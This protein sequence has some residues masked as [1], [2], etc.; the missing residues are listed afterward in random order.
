MQLNYPGE[1]PVV[2][3][4]KAIIKAIQ[5]NQVVIIAGETGSGKTTQLP[6][7]CVEALPDLLKN[8]MIGITQPRRIA[9]SSV[10]ARVAEELQEMGHIV[11]HKIRFYDKTTAAT[12]I[13]FM[14]DGVLLAETK[15]DTLLQQYNVLIIDEAHERSLNIDFLLGYL[16][17][18]LPKRPELKL[19][20][21]S[22]TIDTEAFARHFA[23]APVIVV[24]GRSYPVEISYHP[25]GDIGETGAEKDEE[26][27]GKIEHA[28]AILDELFL[29]R[30][31]GDILL[32]L[33]TEQDIRQ[34]CALLE[35]RYQ[36]TTVLPLFGRLA[37]GDQAKIF[38]PAKGI[39]I[40]VATNVA[41]TSITVPGIRYVIDS[42]Y[43][44]ISR[45][46]VRARTTALP[47]S[48]ISQA[49]A[50]QRAGRAGRIAPGFCLRLY[51]EDDFLQR[52]EFTVPEI[53]RTNLAEVILQMISF[54][55]GEPENFPFLDA[56]N[57]AAIREGYTL[58]RELGAL[59]G[60]NRL[61]PRGR[62][63]ARLP[64]DPCISRILL[65][66]KEN[67]S[68]TE[69]TIIAAVLAIQDPRIRPAE[70]EQ[71][72]DEAH[73]RFRHKYS[74]FLSLLNIWQ[75]YHQDNDKPQS[76][77][78]LKK[79][80][81][82][83]YLSFQRMREWIDLH[84]QLIRIL[85]RE[86]DAF[87]FNRNPANY[88]QIHKALLCGFLRNIARKKQ[89]EGKGKYGGSAPK[90]KNKNIFQGGQNKELA[91]F[92]GSGLFAKPPEWILA[93]NFI[94]TS[95][96]YALTVAAIEP[97]WVEMA[98]SHLCN[99]SWSDPCWHK[100]SG[101][102]LAKETVSLFGL[103]VNTKNRV[104]FGKRNK[105]NSAEARSIFIQQALLTGEL[106]G[107]YPFL[108]HNMALLKKWEESE[109]KLRSRNL[110]ANEQSLAAFYA[111]R[112]PDNIYSQPLLNRFLKKKGNQNFLKMKESDILA[113]DFAEHEILDFPK[114]RTIG[115]L[116][117]SIDYTFSPGSEAD[118]IT[119]RLPVLFAQNTQLYH[120]DWLVPG[121]L[122]EKI[123]FLLKGLV[124]GLRKRLVPIQQSVDYILDEID[125]GKGDLLSAVEAA[126][127]KR[128]QMTI[129][130]S[131]WQ[132]ELPP[133]LT[134]RFLLFDDNDKELAAGRN[135]PLLLQ[136]VQNMQLMQ[137]LPGK[138]PKK[139]VSKE[140]PL[141][142]KWRGTTHNSWSFDELP[143]EIPTYTTAG[144]ISGFLYPALY[145]DT[146][147]GGV[148]VQFIRNRKEALQINEE[149]LLYLFSLQFR[150]QYKQ[151]KRLISTSFSGPSTLF[152][153]GLQ[154]TKPEITAL[155]LTRLLKQIYGEYGAKRPTSSEFT[156]RVT[157]IKKEG[158]YRCG[159]IKW[160]QFMT[161]LRK[162]RTVAEQ[163]AA[164]ASK[165]QA[166]G[167]SNKSGYA[168]L[169][170]EL[171]AIF[172]V[173]IVYKDTDYQ[174][175]SRQ[176]DYFA[177]RLE[178][179]Y[180]SP[181][182]DEQKGK[183]IEPFIRKLQSIDHTQQLSSEAEE[184]LQNYREM[185]IEFKISVFAPE[186][187]RRFAI[188]A[189]KL[190]AQWQ[191]AVKYLPLL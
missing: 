125:F 189:K 31:Q 112:L 73:R 173:Q 48:K 106:N 159:Q 36:A 29:S 20:V 179:F 103:I 130:R 100:K 54:R 37:A 62:I 15:N 76:W 32:F 135:L 162:R 107:N 98:A 183:Q 25:I 188:S 42:G 144:E 3:E 186:I 190:D 131:D 75:D 178:R 13:K 174:E 81:K 14:T 30:P 40:I 43:A 169:E 143:E 63:M 80:C 132:Q 24:P 56:P 38:R 89:E 45:Y 101:Q 66:A 41:E 17:T 4:K 152:L 182:K 121:L 108:D 166:K 19:L 151:L 60:N 97:E 10:A 140:S 28:V 86:K 72:A 138:T 184:A 134:P 141:I 170:Q 158:F 22:A 7:I 70:S 117:I 99:Y 1:L 120:F 77:S 53:Q 65:A 91:I 161:A 49:S 96:L 85:G 23:G 180:V 177:L 145:T 133:H 12:K 61:T 57:P 127:F 168:R 90:T 164:F 34:C 71:Q 11:G 84:D 148:T 94:E 156:S 176:L 55:L 79:Y 50:R 113:R 51:A 124:K 68:L 115:G 47:I 26:Q 157:A 123:T 153:G 6:K 187:K 109:A 119:F 9:A 35:N 155:L 122:G 167:H 93:A 118:G 82:K 114:K 5:N 102:V 104:N 87:I 171:Q 191:Q 69:T 116:A 39:K 44:R 67:N 8:S 110:I 64:V 181:Q 78:A 150:E 88:E 111:K 18:L 160:E 59:Q 149:A 105:K 154:K 83:N 126:I 128:F 33:P 139:S 46:N 146:Q 175:I 136:K 137:S 142:A 58:L 92:P 172:P 21:T 147:Q 129:H 2:A 95:R 52:E 16:K 27:E 74:D 165:S 185:L 163:L